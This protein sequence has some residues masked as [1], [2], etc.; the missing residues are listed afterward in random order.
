MK[1]LT[2]LPKSLGLLCLLIVILVVSGCAP[3][4]ERL[5]RQGNVLK[6]I[7][8]LEHED[9][10]IRKKAIKALGEIHDV[11]PFVAALEDERSRVRQIAAG[12][13]GEL[14]D[15]RAV[16]PLL[17]ALADEQDS[18]VIESITESLIELGIG[19][20]DT[21]LLADTLMEL[22]DHDLDLVM[23]IVLD[24]VNSPETITPWTTALGESGDARSLEF[25]LSLL[26]HRDETVR[27]S[28]VKALAQIGEPAIEPLISVLS[29]KSSFCGKQS[30]VS[31][32]GEIGQPAIEPLLKALKDEDID[33]Q[34]YVA[35]ALGEIADPQAVAD[36]LTLALGGSPTGGM[37]D[38]VLR[39]SAA[40]A[41]GAIGKPGLEPLVAALT[42]WDQK[43]RENAL[44]ALVNIGDPAV[45]MAV[46]PLI[47][48]TKTRIGKDACAYDL[49]EHVNLLID[50]GQHISNSA[51][52]YAIE[53]ALIHALNDC[54]TQALAS[55]Y[56]NS[57]NKRL[58]SAA[59]DW[60][61]DNGYSVISFPSGGSDKSW[62]SP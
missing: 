33:V 25:L 16:Q 5:Q 43:V 18:K 9:Y 61:E 40:Q 36:L 44:E 22:N 17:K 39:K 50:L 37:D 27:Q 42:H 57:G 8:A 35:Q 56:L 58:G 11:D 10:R 55:K 26:E 52:I 41:L 38:Y 62:G 14:G 51:N 24:D 47:D 60:A 12:E 20:Q 59:R 15:P 34:H 46:E 3:N 4:I 45:E 28:A 2:I 29:D 7:Q 6:L 30:A 53:N 49:E 19:E 23:G 54:G 1:S 13:L 32:L 31:A 21:E 48:A